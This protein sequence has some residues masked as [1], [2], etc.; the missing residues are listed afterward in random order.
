MKGS[1]VLVDEFTVSSAVASVIL[2]GGSS[3]SSGL[4]V[5]IDST[6]DV[7]IAQIHSL[8]V[9]TAENLECRVTESG[10]ANATANYDFRAKGLKRSGTFDNNGTTNQNQWDISGSQIHASNGNFNG[11]MYIFNASNAS[12][13]TSISMETSHFAAASEIY[14]NTGGAIFTS[15]SAVDGLFFQIDGGNNIDAGNFK[16]FALKK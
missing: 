2:G 11:I 12:E 5:S 9:S 3:G 14:G 15:A 10:T 16:L 4:N 1:L 8:S 6:Y 13:Y 7:Y